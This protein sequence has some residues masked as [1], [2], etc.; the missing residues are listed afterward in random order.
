MR[1]IALLF[2]IL[3]NLVGLIGCTKNNQNDDSKKRKNIIQ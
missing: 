1:K 2:I 3:F